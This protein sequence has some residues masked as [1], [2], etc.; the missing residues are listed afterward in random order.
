[1]A[2]EGDYELLPHEEIQK[3]RDELEKLKKNPLGTTV[4]AKDLQTSVIELTKAINSLTTLLTDTNDDLTKEFQRTSISEHFSQISTQNEQIAQGILA[5]AQM[6]QQM[7]VPQEPE[8][9]EKT[10]NPP[11][12]SQES[13]NQ[14][15]YPQ[16]QNQSSSMPP[17]PMGSPG[18]PPPMSNPSFSGASM[19]PPALDLPPAPA[20][21]KSGLMGMFK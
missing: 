5:V 20:K 4:Q 21:K 8:V 14:E 10:S 1:M 17:P 15:T 18:M 19:P 12:Y 2:D 11:S 3:L 16:T 9:P 13:P 6:V 7:N